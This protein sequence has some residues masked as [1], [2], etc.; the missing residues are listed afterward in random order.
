MAIKNYAIETGGTDIFSPV[1][2][3]LP[4]GEYA[5]TNIMFCNISAADSVTLTL[6]AIPSGKAS[7]DPETQVIKTLTIP[8]SETF[9]FDT[10]KLVLDQTD[11]V[12]A[13]ASANSRLVATV[14]YMKVS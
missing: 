7:T 14:S 10:E 8:A 4:A 3:S 6:H 9:T 5:I 12:R 2:L 1:A 11:K 13:V